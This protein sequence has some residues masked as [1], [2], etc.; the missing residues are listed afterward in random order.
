MDVVDNCF[1]GTGDTSLCRLNF[2][3]KCP[4]PEKHLGVG[5]HSDPGIITILLQDDSIS[6]LQVLKDGTFHNVPPVKGWTDFRLDKKIT[7]FK[8]DL[9]FSTQIPL[10]LILEI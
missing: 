4:D 8:F 7:K 1:D 2:Y 3:R 9:L 5:P 10:W 6:S